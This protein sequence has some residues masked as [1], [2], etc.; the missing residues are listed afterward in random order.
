MTD[1]ERSQISE[2]QE[3][4]RKLREMNADIDSLLDRRMRYEALATRRTASYSD[5]PRAGRTESGVEYYACK[6]VELDREANERIDQY[7]DTRREVEARVHSITDER[8]RKILLRRYVN[9]WAWDRIASE[10]GLPTSTVRG[11]MH[12]RALKVY[13]R[14]CG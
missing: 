2:A 7:V 14:Y 12:T 11:R 9:W 6:L 1:Y 3:C 4:L 10:L 5:M 13:T 8:Y